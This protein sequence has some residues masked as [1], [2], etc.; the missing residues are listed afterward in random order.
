VDTDAGFI[1][2]RE[3]PGYRRIARR[4]AYV[5]A[6]NWQ[7]R[8]DDI[9]FPAGQRGADT[10]E[11]SRARARKEAASARGGLRSKKSAPKE[12]AVKSP[13]SEEKFV[14]ACIGLAELT[15]LLGI[16]LF[17]RWVAAHLR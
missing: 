10:F 14:L 8:P 5:Q 1:C 6:W 3:R 9:G 11:H 4:R 7:G 17:V 12:D 15:I 13:D 2:S 16:A